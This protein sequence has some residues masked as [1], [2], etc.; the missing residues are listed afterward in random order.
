MLQPPR[1]DQ[2]LAKEALQ[3]IFDLA[4]EYWTQNNDVA[5]FVD[6]KIYEYELIQIFG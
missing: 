4:A 2:L 1:G 6:L 5:N 3:K